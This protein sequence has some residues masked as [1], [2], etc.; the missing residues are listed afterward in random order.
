[1]AMSLKTFHLV[2]ILMAIMGADLFGGWT[3]QEYIRSNSLPTLLI[4][5]A[6]MA[7]GLG[8]IRYAIYFVRMMDRERLG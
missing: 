5:I 6:S 2:F 8:L 1:M 4:G 7:G 3:V